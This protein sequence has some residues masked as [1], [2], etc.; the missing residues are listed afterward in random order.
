MITIAMDNTSKLYQYDMNRRVIISGLPPEGIYQIHFKKYMKDSDVIVKEGV[1]DADKNISA[2][3]P[4]SLLTNSNMIS[5]Y[6][7]G[8]IG[9]VTKTFH[10]ENLLIIPRPK[11]EG[12]VLPDDED[13]VN[14]YNKLVG[15]I[16]SLKNN[17]IGKD[18][19]TDAVGDVV[20]DTLNETVIPIVNKKVDKVEGKGLSTNDFTD[21]YKMLIEEHAYLIGNLGELYTEK[22]ENLVDAV[23][24]IY[25]D[26]HQ[27]PI[28]IIPTTLEPNTQYNFGERASLNLAFPTQAIDGNVIYLTFKSGDVP[29]A[30]T[31]DTTNT[32]DIDVI[33]ESNTGYEI[34]G[35]FNGDI[36]IV[37]YS[38]YTVSEG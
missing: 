22:T 20:A 36:W 15:E 38:E 4:N 16:E 13:S 9:T 12:Y 14:T 31:I 18:D 33:P 19:L 28:T 27:E 5:V 7:Y 6:V 29:T 25:S 1:F 32:C 17:M 30:L 24:E 8:T 23:N 11:P 21:D 3:I 35:K 10:T 26:I 2:Q 34:F 37:N